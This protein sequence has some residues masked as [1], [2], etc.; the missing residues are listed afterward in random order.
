MGRN[1]VP[2]RVMV[3]S[4]T[5]DHSLDG[6]TMPEIDV[7]IHTGDLTNFGELKSLEESVRMIGTISAE[8]KLIIAGNHDISLDKTNRVENMTD[9]EYSNYHA[10]AI[11][12]M[13]G[14]MAKQAGITYLEEGTHTFTLKN[15]STFNVYASPYTVGSGGWAFPYTSNEDRF[16]TASQTAANKISVAQNPIPLD[17]H[18]VMTHGPP[19]SILDQV[20]G[21]NLGCPNLLQA[22]SR[23]RPIMHCFG[24]IHEGHGANIVTW[25]PDGSVNNP[26]AATPMETEQI[27]EYPYAN[28]WPVQSGKQT[29]MVNA[30]IMRNTARG[31]RPDYKPFIVS[32]DLPCP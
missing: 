23:V 14:S 1:T 19:Y 26:S 4:D 6:T 3:I 32:L 5:H 7:L 17:V 13:T 20:D 28:E 21:Q 9:E 22:V 29:L 10:S 18:I 31:M 27:N 11:E 24:H 2:T 12:I 15:G 25:K 16:N 8:L 30:A